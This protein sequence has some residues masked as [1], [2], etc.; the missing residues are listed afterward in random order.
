MPR[1]AHRSSSPTCGWS[2]GSFNT[3]LGHGVRNL[4]ATSAV[5]SD[6]GMAAPAF[7]AAALGEVAPTHFRHAGRTLYVARRGDVPEPAVV[8]SLT[9]ADGAEQVQVLPAEPAPAEAQP[10]DLVLA[11]ATGRPAG[12]TVAAQRL[13]RSRR[14]RRPFAMMSA[15]PSVRR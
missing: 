5:M 14:R 3:G 1:S 7:V 12:Q 6:A 2:C 11:E 15:A 9:A 13:V 10:A 8:C 4:F